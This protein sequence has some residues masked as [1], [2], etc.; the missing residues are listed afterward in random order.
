LLLIVVYFFCSGVSSEGSSAALGE[1]EAF[2]D[3]DALAAADADAL[4][5]ADAAA[6]AEAD[7][8]TSIVFF[9]ANVIHTGLP[10]AFLAHTK[11]VFNSFPGFP[12]AVQVFPFV[13]STAPV[14]LVGELLGLDPT[15]PFAAPVVGVA[16]PALVVGS[17][18]RGGVG[19]VDALVDALVVGFVDGF[20]VAF[21][22]GFVLAI[23][24]VGIFSG[25]T[26]TNPIAIFSA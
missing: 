9:S 15:T 19:F 12:R 24:V 17:G 16:E 23:E 21:L 2:A 3:A 18:G 5:A 20:V 10:A 13:A 6:F 25:I 7:A 11:A 26:S 4:A 14:G 22:L 1:A 8:A